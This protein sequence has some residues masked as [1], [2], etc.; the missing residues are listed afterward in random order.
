MEEAPNQAL[1]RVTGLILLTAVV[2][3]LKTLYLLKQHIIFGNSYYGGKETE[4]VSCTAGQ[5]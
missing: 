1:M 5:K 2:T 3:S 4:V